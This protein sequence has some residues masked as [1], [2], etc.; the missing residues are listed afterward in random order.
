MINETNLIKYLLEDVLKSSEEEIKEEVEKNVDTSSV[1]A[2]THDNPIKVTE[3]EY[4]I[5]EAHLNM[6][7]IFFEVSFA[8]RGK[9][10]I[11][12]KLAEGYYRIK[13]TDIPVEKKDEVE[14][15]KEEKKEI[16]PPPYVGGYPEIDNNPNLS[17]YLKKMMTE[18]KRKAEAHSNANLIPESGKK[19][20]IKPILPP[21]EDN[22]M[23]TGL[24][25]EETLEDIIGGKGA[26]Q[27][28]QSDLPGWEPKK[29]TLDTLPDNPIDLGPTGGLNNT[30]P[31]AGIAPLSGVTTDEF[32]VRKLIGNT[33]AQD[34]QTPPTSQTPPTT[35]QP[36]YVAN[37][38]EDV[39]DYR[40]YVGTPETGFTHFDMLLGMD[41]PATISQLMG[42][43]YSQ[44]LDVCI[45]IE[46]A[47][48]FLTEGSIPLAITENA[49]IAKIT[50]DAYGDV[51]CLRITRNGDEYIVA[52]S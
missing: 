14:N 20:P 51:N 47:N 18:E 8:D 4:L 43:A 16:T 19:E 36:N 38:S 9:E 11:V 50:D 28:N 42:K 21:V 48:Q 25:E 27:V 24:E 46:R 33:I 2:A 34:A 32:D 44:H 29:E 13:L 35:E 22:G 17:D 41:H 30:D 23:G 5:K 40:L 52:V 15:K 1:D 39:L 10:T 6:F 7:K 37:Q 31:L 26:S 12:E 3:T 45:P 49:A